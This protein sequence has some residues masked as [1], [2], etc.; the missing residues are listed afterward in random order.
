MAPAGRRTYGTPDEAEVVMGVLVGQRHE[1]RPQRGGGHGRACRVLSA[2]ALRPLARTAP[3]RR[4]AARLGM[5]D[6]G[7]TERWSGLTARQY[8]KVISLLGS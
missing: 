3:P 7:M 2:G 6:E 1:S 5:T 4:V 8:R